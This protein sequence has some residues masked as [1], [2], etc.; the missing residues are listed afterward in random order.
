MA[1]C[2]RARSGCSLRRATPP[3]P[4]TR[5][6]PSVVSSFGAEVVA[7][8]PER[9]DALVAVV[10]HVPHLTAATLMGVAETRAEE[11]AALLRLA[12]GGFRDMT[13]IASGHPAI[14]QDICREN[15]GAIVEALD[16][17]IEG[18]GDMRE[19]VDNGDGAAL[20]AR[21]EGRSGRPREP[22]ESR[23]P[24]VG[25]R[26]GAHPGAR[27]SGRARRGHD[28]RR[29]ARRE[30]R[31]HRDRAL[32]R[33]QPRCGDHARRGGERRSVPR[34]AHG[35]RLPAVGAAARNERARATISRSPHRPTSPSGCR[36]EE[37]HEPGAGRRRAC[38]RRSAGS[39]ACCS[40]TTPRR[41]SSRSSAS[42]S[43]LEIDR[44]ARG[45]RRARQPAARSRSRRR[46]STPR[47]SGTTA[48]F[49]LPMLALGPGRYRLDGTRRC[50]R[51][52]WDLR[53]TRCAASACASSR[54][55]VRVTFRSRSRPTACG[56][57]RCG[58]RA[59]CR[60]SSSRGSCSP[61]RVR[62]ARS[63]SRSTETRCRSRTSR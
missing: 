25:S 33:G 27:P 23:G 26:R 1:S 5:R 54:T 60:A 50:G 42:A 15:R 55:T 13:R 59:T 44:D 19:V 53:S 40:R 36:V 17:L 8:A 37:H 34:R 12:A 58:C 4:R 41:C 56:A 57:A 32:G 48:R 22:A 21:L 51:V 63:T 16:A 61:R 24:P 9:H 43:R 49:L 10:S 31:R 7:V 52:R 6:S 39:R 2:S 28:A 47:Q 29:R 20:L 14:W 38:R 30:H 62:T 18:L 45:G 35:A 3:T 46:R 11:H